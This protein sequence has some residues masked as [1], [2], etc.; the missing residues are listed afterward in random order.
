MLFIVVSMLFIVILMLFLV[1]H[2]GSS[3]FMVVYTDLYWFRPFRYREYREN[4]RIY[5]RDNKH[6][7][8]PLLRTLYGNPCS[9]TLY[10]LVFFSIDT[11]D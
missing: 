7:S 8:G 6:S 11:D 10:T 2:S 3:W 4:V 5:G 1:I 9:S